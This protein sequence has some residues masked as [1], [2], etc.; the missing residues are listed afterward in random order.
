M[1]AKEKVAR[2]SFLVKLTTFTKGEK[3]S[4]GYYDVMK[5]EIQKTIADKNKPL[6]KKSILEDEGQSFSDILSRYNNKILDFQFLMSWP[7]TSRPWAICNE[8]EKS[9]V[10][11][12]HLH[13]NYLQ[14]LAHK[15][16]IHGST[17]IPICIVDAMK[18]VRMIPISELI[19]PVYK[20]W[21]IN[22]FEYMKNIQCDTLHIVFDVYPS[23]DLSL[24]SKGRYDPDKIGERRHV[25]SL[26]Q[27]LPPNQKAW[28]SYLSNDQNKRELTQ[29]LI[30][31]VLN[32]NYSFE[33]TVF[34][35]RGEKC[36]LKR[37]NEMAIEVPELQTYVTE[38]DP[39]LALHAV[40][41]SNLYPNQSVCVVADDTDVY[42]LLLS[43]ASQM[44]STLLFRQGTSIEYHNVSALA[45]H[46]G[47]ECCKNLP[48]FHALTGCDFTYTFYGRSKNRA[49]NMMINIS[50]SKKRNT[51]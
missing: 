22:V 15:K 36:F 50:K 30:D 43:V 24:P 19:P 29:L 1:L 39:R 31:F 49:F 47:Y 28:N 45:E 18:I 41:S 2:D 51:T 21:A 37:P 40:Y 6:G 48:A 16:P 26:S 12:K 33:K 42:I 7:V 32:G 44:K 10:V 14:T 13:R 23:E 34:I 46:L 17:F 8:E 3:T 38:A 20:T 9:R 35:T 25:S 5:K 11:R 27:R 4:S